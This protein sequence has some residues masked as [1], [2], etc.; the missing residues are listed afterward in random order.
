M[1]SLVNISA[2]YDLKRQSVKSG[3]IEPLAGYPAEAG[4][5]RELAKDFSPCILSVARLLKPVS[6]YARQDGLETANLAAGIA[7]VSFRQQ[8]RKWKFYR[9]AAE[10]CSV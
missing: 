9:N 6:S 10:L 5:V 2:A 8:G 1:F 4:P 7:V 3:M